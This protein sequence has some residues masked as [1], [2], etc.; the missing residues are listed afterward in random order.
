[1]TNKFVVGT[2]RKLPSL[3][4]YCFKRGSEKKIAARIQ[5]NAWLL[6]LVD[7]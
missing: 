7:Q 3:E 1:M 6:I 4:H 2:G 5:V